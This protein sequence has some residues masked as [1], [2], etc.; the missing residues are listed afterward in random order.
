MN[1]GRVILVKR[2]DKIDTRAEPSSFK[3]ST[4]SSEGSAVRKASRV[5]IRRVWK[6]ER[7]PRALLLLRTQLIGVR[8]A[9]KEM[10]DMKLNHNLVL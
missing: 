3:G 9:L 4:D 10:C 2:E 6:V 7:F 5:C 1:E 8:G